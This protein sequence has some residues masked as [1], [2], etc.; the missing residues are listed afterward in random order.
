MCEKYLP[1]LELDYCGHA[2]PSWDSTGKSVLLSYSACD[3][4][5]RMVRVTFEG[6]EAPSTPTMS[7]TK[8]TRMKTTRTKT[9]TTKTKAS[10][11]TKAKITKSSPSASNTISPSATRTNDIMTTTSTRKTKSGTSKAAATAGRITGVDSSSNSTGLLKRTP[12]KEDMRRPLR[13]SRKLLRRE[14]E[15]RDGL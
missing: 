10:K 14:R 1:D 3:G 13:L 8:T 11:T 2:Y 4:W 9:K 6:S 12:A 7:K 5:T 15:A